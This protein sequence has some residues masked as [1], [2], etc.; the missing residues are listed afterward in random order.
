MNQEKQ[1]EALRLADDLDA[2]NK[3]PGNSKSC[4]THAAAELR[5]L[6]ARV[7]ELEAV[8]KAACKAYNRWAYAEDTLGEVT[9]AMNELAEV[10]K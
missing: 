10:L 8:K 5:R 4:N 7:Q 2:S 9:Q 3:F 6:H 1:P